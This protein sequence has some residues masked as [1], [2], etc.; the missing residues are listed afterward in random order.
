M[1]LQVIFNTIVPDNI[2]NLPLVKK[3]SEI[4]IEQLNRNSQISMRISKIYEPDSQ[5][6]IKIDEEGNI[7]E[8]TD[9]EFLKRSKVILKTGLLYTYLNVITSL[10]YKLCEKSLINTNN[11]NRL[12]SEYLSGFRYYQQNIGT[13]KAIHYMYAF[14][15]YLET[16]AVVRDLDIEEGSV[17]NLR[18]DGSLQ[19]EIF[20]IFNK[21][22]AH[23]CGWLCE[24]EKTK[25]ADMSVVIP[26]YEL[27]LDSD[28][29]AQTII[30]NM[31][32]YEVSNLFEG[33][34]EDMNGVMPYRFVAHEDGYA[35]EITDYEFEWYDLDTTEY[36][37]LEEKYLWISV[38]RLWSA[39]D[40]GLSLARG[41][42]NMADIQ[43]VMNF[44][45]YNNEPSVTNFN[46]EVCLYCNPSKPRQRMYNSVTD[47]YLYD[48][49]E[50]FESTHNFRYSFDVWIPAN[51]INIL[52]SD[53][54]ETRFHQYH[55]DHGNC[56]QIP[57]F[58]IIKN[59]P[60]DEGNS[61]NYDNF[62][63]F[64][65]GYVFG[66]YAGD[67]NGKLKSFSIIES[68]FMTNH[69]N[70]VLM[71]SM[72]SGDKTIYKYYVNGSLIHTHTENT[73]VSKIATSVIKS[74]Q[75]YI[76]TLNN[77]PIGA[78]GWSLSFDNDLKIANLLVEFSVKL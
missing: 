1:D 35:L 33:L 5:N 42:T 70:K 66:M 20:S 58:E 9:S 78:N 47:L 32:N 64:M 31:G 53:S 39:N 34:I 6:W 19:K 13:S 3:C 72:I 52:Y 4:F 55:A 2:R 26:E 41:F 22:V 11:I 21:Q 28:F 48:A 14:A 45:E 68:P 23:P 46:G 76:G 30:D 10:V 61:K 74:N 12:N 62:A 73:T 65:E 25:V 29:N 17:F 49:K 75:Y 36:P 71:E 44:R 60:E 27:I 69:W 43:N 56:L 40:V 63:D 54:D 7:S 67:S 15:K 24:Y 59:L 16:G 77:A 57:M 51:L 37:P 18:Y 38:A 50:N 8:I